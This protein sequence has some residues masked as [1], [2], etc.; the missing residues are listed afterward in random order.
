MI[1]VQ[2]NCNQYSPSPIGQGLPAGTEMQGQ[3]CIPC[4][5]STEAPCTAHSPCTVH[6]RGPPGQQV[7]VLGE[8]TLSLP[9]EWFLVQALSKLNFCRAL[10]KELTYYLSIIYSLHTVALPF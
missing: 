8:V 5:P 2:Y 9:H 10:K 6:L 1:V 3:E 4:L 7:N